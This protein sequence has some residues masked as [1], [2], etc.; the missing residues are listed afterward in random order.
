MSK[1]NYSIYMFSG[2]L[3][4]ILIACETGNNPSTET[5]SEKSNPKQDID[6][7]T[8]VATSKIQQELDQLEAQLGNSNRTI[9]QQ[10]RMIIQRLGDLSEKTIADIG[11][12]P[13]GYFSFQ[14]VNEAKKVIAIDIDPK[15]LA[16]M[17]SLRTDILP[18]HK[19]DALVTRLASPNNPNLKPAE[20]DV[21]ILMN[22]YAYLPNSKQYL[23]T[24]KRGLTADG[25]LLIVD[26]KMRSIPLGPPQE[27]K[28][29]LYVI[30]QDLEKAGFKIELVDD[31][32]LAYQYLIIASK[33]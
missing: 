5:P 1:I 11:A 19:L 31:R 29:P 25:K 13:F 24:L 21:I 16:F 12:G 20:A 33:N 14:L 3:L 9:W 32:T 18:K 23:E 26:F 8:K 28:V 30:E 15:A 6:S 7:T 22:I 4:F 27:E 17:D 10:P 2:L